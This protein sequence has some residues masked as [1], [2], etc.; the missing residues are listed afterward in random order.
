MNFIEPSLLV[1]YFIFF[2]AAIVVVGNLLS[3]A[4]AFLNLI[5][6]GRIPKWNTIAVLKVYF[7]PVTWPFKTLWGLIGK[8]MR[9]ILK[10][11]WRGFVTVLRELL[12]AAWRGTLVILAA[13]W[14][15][16]RGRTP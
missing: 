16:L 13:L 15:R 12:A 1:G 2:P 14:S 7:I 4:F 9:N 8:R 6:I 11:A 3:P 10:A 5:S